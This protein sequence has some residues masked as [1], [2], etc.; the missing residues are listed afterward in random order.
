MLPHYSPMKVAEQFR[1]L[2]SLHAG[3]IDLGL[4]RAPGGDARTAAALQAG[5]QAWPVEV[6]P[7]QV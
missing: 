2:A 4:G 3:R 7:Q 1:M 6:F 5:P